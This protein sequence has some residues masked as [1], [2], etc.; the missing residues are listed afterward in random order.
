MG[1]SRG[2]LVTFDETVVLLG[3]DGD[4]R[5][6]DLLPPNKDKEDRL[7]VEDYAEDDWDPWDIS[8]SDGIDVQSSLRGDF[9]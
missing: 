6:H 7:S 5:V 8:P 4:D 9:W 2:D 3:L 1:R